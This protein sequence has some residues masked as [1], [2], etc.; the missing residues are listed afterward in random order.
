MPM[1]TFESYNVPLRPIASAAVSLKDHG[2]DEACAQNSEIVSDEGESETSSTWS[3]RN[4]LLHQSR[5]GRSAKP[6]YQTEKDHCMARIREN[7]NGGLAHQVEDILGQ[8]YFGE[9]IL[10]KVYQGLAALS[11]R[12]LG[13]VDTAREMLDRVVKSG[14]RKDSILTKSDVYAAHKLLDQENGKEGT[15]QSA[16]RPRKWRK[17]GESQAARVAV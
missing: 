17:R 3:T 8:Q 11:S 1:P 16:A 15:P 2:E 13:D 9:R 5:P 4:A 7:W 10:R 12:T 6:R 14:N